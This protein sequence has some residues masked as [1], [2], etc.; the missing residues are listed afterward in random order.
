MLQ[1]KQQVVS[2]IVNEKLIVKINISLVEANSAFICS[3]NNFY[4]KYIVGPKYT[5]KPVLEGSSQ[6]HK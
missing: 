2:E 4:L 1:W 6:L 5:R 3:R